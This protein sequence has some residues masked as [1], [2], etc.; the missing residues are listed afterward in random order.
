MGAAAKVLMFGLVGLMAVVVFVPGVRQSFTRMFS[1]SET[2]IVPSSPRSS[3]GSSPAQ[4]DVSLDPATGQ[5]LRLITLLGYDAIPAILDPEFLDAEQAQLEFRPEEQVLG[6]SIN[7]DNRAY[8]IPMLSR[9]EI[10]NDVVG[11]VPVAVTW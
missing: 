3:S 7:G 9:H 2:I 11:G 10:V 4:T 6:L 1:N 5:E 8:S